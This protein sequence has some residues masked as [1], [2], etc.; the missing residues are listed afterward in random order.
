VLDCY[1]PVRGFAHHRLICRKVAKSKLNVSYANK[2]S[3]TDDIVPG[4]A[5]G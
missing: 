5:A 2:H 4:T 1:L 3:L